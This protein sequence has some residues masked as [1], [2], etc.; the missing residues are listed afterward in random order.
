M[1]AVTTDG[2]KFPPGTLKRKM[3]PEENLQKIIVVHIQERKQERKNHVTKELMND[4][5]PVIWNREKTFQ[6]PFHKRLFSHFTSFY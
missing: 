3:I 1:P 5:L 4:E 2:C 6:G